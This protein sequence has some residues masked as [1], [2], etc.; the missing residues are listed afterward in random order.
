MVLLASAGYSGAEGEA[1]KFWPQWRGPLGTGVSAHADPPLVWAENKNI[2]W[3]IEIPGRG[4]ASPVVWGNTPVSVDRRARRCGS[5]RIAS[6]ARRRQ[7]AG[8]A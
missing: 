2:K 7:P 3:K 8:R 1:D 5:G 4:S 6:A